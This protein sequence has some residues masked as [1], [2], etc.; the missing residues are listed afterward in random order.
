MSTRSGEIHFSRV[1]GLAAVVFSALYFLS[2]VLEG[3]HGGFTASQLVITYVAEAAI[4]LFVLGLYA[5]QRPHIGVLGLVGAGGYAW[6]YVFFTGTVM[7]ALV[8]E[9]PDWATL[10]GD[11]DPWLTLHGSL[12]LAAGSAL[13]VAVVRAGVFPRWTG[14]LLVAGVVLVAMASVLPGQVQLL[15]AGV[16]D[17]AFVGMGV[18]LLTHT[19]PAPRTRETRVSHVRA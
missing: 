19:R 10:S 15:C 9:S 8:T 5:V 4:P 2:D 11:L 18:H 17:L 7:V 14:V 3:V 13:G 1:V 12:M 6:A 16:R